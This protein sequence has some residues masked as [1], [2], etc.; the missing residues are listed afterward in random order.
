MYK[1]NSS[2]SRKN[3]HNESK[4]YELHCNTT[5]GVKTI[6]NS[7]RFFKKLGM[8]LAQF[9]SLVTF[10]LVFLLVLLGFFKV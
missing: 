8:H 10:V 2:N 1:Q 4:L 5:R 9:S 6:V 7:I 3:K